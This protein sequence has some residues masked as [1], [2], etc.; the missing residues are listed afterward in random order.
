MSRLPF[1]RG[2]S[3]FIYY[4]PVI[5]S[6]AEVNHGIDTGFRVILNIDAIIVPGMG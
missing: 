3:F 5:N 2:A 1:K 4:P 6:T